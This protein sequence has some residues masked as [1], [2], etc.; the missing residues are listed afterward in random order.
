VRVDAMALGTSYVSVERG[1]KD[2]EEIWVSLKSDGGRAV[3]TVGRGDGDAVLDLS[4]GR[5]RL[6]FGAD[7]KAHLAVTVLPAPGWDPD[8][9]T[10]TRYATTLVF[11]R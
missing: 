2:P 11:E 4:S 8:A 6:R 3:Q 5:A 10:G 9:E 7:G 1:A